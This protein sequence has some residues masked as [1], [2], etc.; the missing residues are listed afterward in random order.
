MESR[1]IMSLWE[2]TGLR[3]VGSDWRHRGQGGRES[4]A[5]A[6]L[7]MES[8]NRNRLPTPSRQDGRAARSITPLCAR[9]AALAAV[10][11][12]ADGW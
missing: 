1:E 12:P 3:K 8:E 10:G 5:A 4:I 11:R 2:W 6:P 7:L 9:A